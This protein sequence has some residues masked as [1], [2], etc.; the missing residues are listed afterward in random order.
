MKTAWIVQKK[1]AEIQRYIVG[2]FDTY[3][4]AMAEVFYLKSFFPNDWKHYG[5]PQD[6][7]R[8]QYEDV[9]ITLDEYEVQ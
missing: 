7:Q 1:E 5:Y 4:K 8:W 3:E 9:I 6:H 2:I